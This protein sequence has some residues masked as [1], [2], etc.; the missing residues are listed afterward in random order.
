MNLFVQCR[1]TNYSLFNSDWTL[2]LKY[3]MQLVYHK[4]YKFVY[5][6]ITYFKLRVNQN[7]HNLRFLNTSIITYFK[8]RVNQNACGIIYIEGN[9][10]T[11][12]KLRVNQNSSCSHNTFYYIITYFKLRVNQNYGIIR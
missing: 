7:S 6:I 2:N 10:I 4:I 12:F 9:I 3:I 8:L 5:P 1:G 11:Y